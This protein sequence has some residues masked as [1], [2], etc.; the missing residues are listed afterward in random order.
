VV[1]VLNEGTTF[2]AVES[3]WW[4]KTSDLFV[5]EPSSFPSFFVDDAL[6]KTRISAGYTT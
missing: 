3:A 6:H 2:T 1:V 5:P 4:A